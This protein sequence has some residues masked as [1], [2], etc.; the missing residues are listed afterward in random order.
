MEG[1]AIGV[2]ILALVFSLFTFFWRDITRVKLRLWI[3][4]DDFEWVAQKGEDRPYAQ[5]INRSPFDVRV[6]R[7]LYRVKRFRKRPLDFPVPLAFGDTEALPQVIEARRS[8]TVRLHPSDFTDLHKFKGKLMIELDTL[9]L[10]KL[11]FRQS[12]KL[13]RYLYEKVRPQD[14]LADK[15]SNDMKTWI[16]G[17]SSAANRDE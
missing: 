14:E 17:E 5:I 7:M 15:R 6:R 3:P 11:G 13:R 8:H 4:P 1:I 10:R 9:Q 2:S 12:R 16:K